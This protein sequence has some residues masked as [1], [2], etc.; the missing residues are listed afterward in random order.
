MHI[1]CAYNVQEAKR[2]D[3]RSH[4]G[5]QSV[6]LLYLGVK[7]PGV[8]GHLHLSQESVLSKAIVVPHRGLQTSSLQLRVADNILQ[9]TGETPSHFQQAN[10]SKTNHTDDECEKPKLHD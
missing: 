9:K 6:P 2:V 1:K 8:E 5:L 3:S 4:L 7:L 10:I